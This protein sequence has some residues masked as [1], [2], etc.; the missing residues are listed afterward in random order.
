MVNR[1]HQFCGLLRK[2]ELYYQLFYVLF[3]FFVTSYQILKETFRSNY[4]NFEEKQFS[5]GIEILIDSKSDV[6]R[7]DP[8]AS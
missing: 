4:Q 2:P 7:L 6:S 8:N 5:E 3:D 1:W